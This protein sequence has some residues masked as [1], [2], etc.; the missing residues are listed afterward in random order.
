MANTTQISIKSL[1]KVFGSSI[2]HPS[3]CSYSFRS[4]ERNCIEWNFPFTF[5]QINAHGAQH[6]I[7][8]TDQFSVTKTSI[9]IYANTTN[10]C[11]LF[12]LVKIEWNALHIPVHL[13]YCYTAYN[14]V[15]RSFPVNMISIAIDP[16][17]N[18]FFR[19][20]PVMERITL[21]GMPLHITADWCTCCTTY[22][23]ITDHSRWSRHQ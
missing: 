13:I 18:I 16:A 15:H 22:N 10:T 19:F 8:S 11:F 6:I 2:R 3:T 9:A 23:M 21:S 5:Q 7:W 1:E 17:P 14:K 12:Y 20:Y 4:I